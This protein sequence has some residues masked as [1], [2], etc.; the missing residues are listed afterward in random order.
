[1]TFTIDHDAS[2][3]E[4]NAF[5]EAVEADLNGEPDPGRLISHAPWTVRYPETTTDT[6]SGRREVDSELVELLTGVW[7]FHVAELPRR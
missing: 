4:W 6:A 7:G 1:M 2:P 3:E 5:I